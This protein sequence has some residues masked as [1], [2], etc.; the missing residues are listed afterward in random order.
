MTLFGAR[1][2]LATSSQWP[3]PSWERSA[4]AT[5]TSIFSP[6]KR[7]ACGVG[8]HFGSRGLGHKTA[9]YFSRRPAA[10]TAWTWAPAVVREKDLI[11]E[12]YI[13][14]LKLAGRYA[15]AGREYVARHV[16]RKSSGRRSGKRCTT[17][18]TSH[19]RRST[20][21]KKLWVV[22]KGA[23]PAFPGQKG[24]VG[25]SMGD[26]AVI[27]EGVESETSREALQSTV[28]GAGRGMSRTAAKGKFVADETAKRVRKDGL[29]RHDEM[30]KWLHDRGVTLRGG[31]L[32]E[33]PQGV[34]PP[35]RSIERT[36]GHDPC[37]PRARASSAWPWRAA[38]SVIRIRTQK[39]LS[40]KSAEQ[41]GP[42]RSIA[43]RPFCMSAPRRE[44]ARRGFRTPARMTLTT[45]PAPG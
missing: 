10:R 11:G 36:R 13:A 9:T 30:M 44:S 31:D 29:V 14:G 7:T 22:R 1:S 21:A 2:P 41:K 39:R 6:T 8:V 26:D 45:T 19:G 18:T 20:T 5:T 4:A 28:H 40:R 35:P 37:P 16:V 15:Y 24:F 33:A 17:T 3:R 42:P 25:G 34:P 32:D 12:A 38:T 27:S 23:T 43:G